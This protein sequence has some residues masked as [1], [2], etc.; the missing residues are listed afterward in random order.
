MGNNHASRQPTT[1]IINNKIQSLMP[2]LFFEL[3]LM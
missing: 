1:A 2:F 3:S